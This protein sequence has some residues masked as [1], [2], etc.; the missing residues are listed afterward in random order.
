MTSDQ[1]A[2]GA[3][4]PEQSGPPPR[5]GLPPWATLVTQ[6]V[7]P[8]T[9]ISG[10]LFYYG[11]VFTPAELWYFGLDVDTVG[12]SPREIV[13]RS[14]RSLAVPLVVLTTT[15]VGVA[16]LH[17]R[18]DAR[19]R[20]LR[21]T[22]AGARR[23]VRGARIAVGAGAAV[24]VSGV[25]LLLAYAWLSGWAWLQVVAASVIAVGAALTAGA[26]RHLPSRPAGVT[27]GLWALVVAAVLWAVS[28]TAGWAGVGFA[29]Q[30]A[31]DLENLPLVV[32]DTT[33]PLRLTN[34]QVAV[35]D[36]CAHPD[37]GTVD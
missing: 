26:L 35:E 33:T 1:P 23:V 13:M 6:L 19:A 9:L 37:S 29:Q 18:V 22:P 8:A 14:P 15:F 11:Y 17:A 34:P 4:P 16:S 5:R 25:L 24:L 2:A 32:L 27:A 3:A 10:F 31:R 21:V 36:L 12:L 7:A 28:E 30:T 20:A